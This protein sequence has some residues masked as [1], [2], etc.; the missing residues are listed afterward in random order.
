[1]AFGSSVL[2]VSGVVVGC[3]RDGLRE[4]FEGGACRVEGSGRCGGGFRQGEEPFGVHQGGS[5]A[6]LEKDLAFSAVAGFADSV[7]LEFGELALDERSSSEFAS[8]G[9]PDLFRSGGLQTGFVE[10]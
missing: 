10:V 6:Q 4:G 3:I 1:M 7:P 2:D 8:G 9:R 5:E